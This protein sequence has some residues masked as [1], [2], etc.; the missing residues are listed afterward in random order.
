MSQDKVE[1]IRMKLGLEPFYKFESNALKREHAE[2]RYGSYM[3]G[4]GITTHMLVR[5]L[6]DAL[7]GHNVV[8]MA[9]TQRSA[10]DL[11][12]QIEKWEAKLE[13]EGEP[14]YKNKF[15]LIIHTGGAFIRF[16]NPTF[17]FDGFIGSVYTDHHCFD[18]F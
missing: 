12:R 16:V 18:T 7:N 6:A 17:R 4:T 3:R 13:L 2:G 15:S 11:F 10:Q 14:W 9:A 8:V 1:I 5:A